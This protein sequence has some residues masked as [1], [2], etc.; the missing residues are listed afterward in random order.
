MKHSALIAA[1]LVL[2]G[3]AATAKESVIHVVIEP[4]PAVDG[5]VQV[6]TGKSTV[7]FDGITPSNGF[8]VAGQL[9]TECYVNDD[10]PASLTTEFFIFSGAIYTTPFGYKPIGPVSVFC[11]PSVGG[12]P[13]PSIIARAW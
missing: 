11:D 5:T 1:V 13:N 9:G 2:A 7:L 4:Q 12:P 3:P 10:G 8:S 6:T